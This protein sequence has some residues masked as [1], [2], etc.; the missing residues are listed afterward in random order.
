VSAVPDH[1]ELFCAAQSIELA[2]PGTFGAAREYVQIRY[3]ALHPRDVQYLS[4][5]SIAPDVRR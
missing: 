5:G 4:L 2:G 1:G 3:P